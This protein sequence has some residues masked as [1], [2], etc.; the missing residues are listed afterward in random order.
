VTIQTYTPLHGDSFAV[1]VDEKSFC[2]TMA[3]YRRLYPRDTRAFEDMSSDIQH[4]IIR[5][6]KEGV[7]A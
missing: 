7:S 3:E 4:A 5:A 6:A 2:R 1:K